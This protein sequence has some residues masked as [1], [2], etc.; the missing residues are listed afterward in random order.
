MPRYSQRFGNAVTFT[1]GLPTTIHL[2]TLTPQKPG[3]TLDQMLT[4][5]EARTHC[6][7]GKC[8]RCNI[9][10]KFTCVDGLVFCQ[11]EVVRFLED[12]LQRIGQKAKV[13]RGSYLEELPNY[14]H[15]F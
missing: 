15:V 2:V 7:I 1:C 9:G 13:L 3:F 10:G 6:G 5:L 4:T 12:F 8:R 14:F 11:S